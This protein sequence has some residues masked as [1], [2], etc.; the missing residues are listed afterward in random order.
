MADK[1]DRLSE[2]II[3]ALDLPGRKE[4]LQMAG[5]LAGSGCRAKVGLE[6]YA[7]EGP[8]LI[9][10][11]KELGFPVFL[12][13]KLHDI[14]ATVERTVRA[15]LNWEPEMLD[16]HCSGG[17]EMMARAAEALH[18][19]GARRGYKPK[20]LGITVLTSMSEEAL[21]REL[22]V[23][24]PLEEQV[25]A[26]ARLAQRAGL[27]GVVASAREAPLLRR[28]LGPDFLLVTPGIRPPGSAPDDQARVLT[29][30]EALAAGSSYLVIGRPITRAEN[31]RQAL[32]KIWEEAE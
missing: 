3:V 25:A 31:P 11:L 7:Y 8:R 2:K 29:P 22:G 28:A 12:D 9:G 21:Q 14:P 17:Y 16:V 19:A 23:K 10:E 15:L 13:L 20:L 1:P 30:R 18:E 5:A 27:D 4:A 26:L 6:L 24:V 32:A